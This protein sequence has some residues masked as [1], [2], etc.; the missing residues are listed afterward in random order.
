M[1]QHLVILGVIAALSKDLQLFDPQK[2]DSDEAKYYLQK[3]W[4]CDALNVTI[5]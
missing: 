3:F 4:L 1:Y 2:A 5:M